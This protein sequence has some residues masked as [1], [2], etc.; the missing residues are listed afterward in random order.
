MATALGKTITSALIWRGFVKGRGVFLAHSTDILKDAMKDYARVYGPKIKL[1]LYNGRSKNIRGADIVFATFQ[2]MTRNLDLFTRKHFAWMTVDETHHAQAKTFKRV[3]VHFLCP[4]L[5]ITATPDRT[6]LLDIRELFGSEVVNFTLEEA[7][8]RGW[9]P[10]IE[11]HIVTDEGFDEAALQRIMREV[12]QEGKRLSLQEINRRVFIRAR[13]EK[14]ARKIEKYKEKSIIFCRNVA[15]AEHFKRF[16]RSAES[17]HSKRTPKQNE[18]ALENLRNGRT[19]RVL[20]VNAFNEGIN[21]PDVGLVVFYRTTESDTIFRQQLGRG[22]RPPKEKLIVLDFVGNLQRIQKLKEMADEVARLHEKFTSERERS[23]EGYVRDRMHVSGKGFNFTFSDTVIDLMKVVERV[24]VNFYQTWEDAGSVAKKLCIKS[25]V[26]YEQR[27]REDPRLPFSPPQF[28][29]DFPGWDVFL[30]KEGFYATWQEARA[31]KDKL[32]AKNHRHYLRLRKQ[33][34]RLPANPVRHY[35]ISN[36]AFWGIKPKSFYPNWR[37]AGTAAQKLGIRDAL[38]YAKRYK[39]DPRLCSRPDE[40]YKDF[41]GY[42]KFLG[43]SAYPTWREAGKA[44]VKLGIRVYRGDYTVKR[45]KDPR[46]PSNPESSYS[47]FPGWPRFLNRTDL[48]RARPR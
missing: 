27:Y 42:G 33:D 28:Y 4:R 48:R 19:R 8:A 40:I 23:R 12:L 39:E 18:C 9:L 36:S 20:S 21:V 32:G 1:A 16:L 5:G 31:A 17:F 3:I 26:Q 15:H 6:D 2:T 45:K 41:P 29:R 35:G 38:E 24:S 43:T 34:P 44:A 47:D 11:Y 14:L 37:M 13:D 46:L 10:K 30:R 25:R 7:I 22:M